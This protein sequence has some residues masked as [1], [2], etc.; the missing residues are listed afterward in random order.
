MMAYDTERAQFFLCLARAFMVPERPGTR[1]AFATCLADDLTEMARQLE[2]PALGAVEDFRA[3]M[4]QASDDLALLRHYAKLFLTPPAPVKINAGRYLDG[5]ARGGSELAMEQV[6]RRYGLVRAEGFHDLADHVSVQLEFVATLFLRAANAS[7]P[8]AARQVED[9]ARR[10][11]AEFP[12]RWLP[13]FCAELGEAVCEHAMGE[14]Y[15]H[16]SRVLSIAVERETALS[17]KAQGVDAVS[18][19]RKTVPLAADPPTPEQLRRIAA[20][21]EA[22]GLATGHL[23]LPLK[24]RDAAM[25]LQRATAGAAEAT[26]PRGNCEER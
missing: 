11:L 17:T 24:C 10:F 26:A 25:G 18:R 4:R 8:A 15:L 21:L 16:L 5:S 1:H 3:S 19:R 22:H 2:Y 12:H 6:Y 23:Q 9:D 13:G 7:D 14:P 20:A